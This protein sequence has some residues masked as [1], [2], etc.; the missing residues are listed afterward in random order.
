[1][2][3]FVTTLIIALFDTG[4]NRIFDNNEKELCTRVE[5]ERHAS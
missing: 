2:F 5:M 1:M 4:K 3:L